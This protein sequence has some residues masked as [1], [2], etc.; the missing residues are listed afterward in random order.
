MTFSRAVVLASRLKFWKTKPIFLFLTSAR[1]SLSSLE[2]SLPS[3]QY[4]PP[5]GL[6][7]QPRMFISVLLP[8]PETPVSATISPRSTFRVMPFKTGSEMSPMK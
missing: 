1:P 4:S 2:I 7:R 3:S 8:E 6:S 5:V